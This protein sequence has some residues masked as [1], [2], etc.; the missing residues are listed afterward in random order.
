MT[1]WYAYIKCSGAYRGIEHGD[2]EDEHILN[3]INLILVL[4]QRAN[5]DTV[6][7]ITVK[8]LDQNFSAVRFERDTVWWKSQRDT[9]KRVM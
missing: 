2:V 5:R 3:N 6:R 1:I 7:T 4:A 9:S 8:V